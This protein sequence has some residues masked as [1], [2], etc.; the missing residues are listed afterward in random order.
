M[1]TIQAAY[2][3][4]FILRLAFSGD[5]LNL[6]TSV[7]ATLVWSMLF[8]FVFEMKKVDNKLSSNSLAESITRERRLRCKKLLLYSVFIAGA[9]LPVW[10]Y[11]VTVMA[12][13]D[14]PLPVEVVRAFDIAFVVRGLAA[15]ATHG[16]MHVQFGLTLRSFVKRK[17]RV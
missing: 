8:F 1:Y 16:Y 4:S 7:A 10:A 11:Y 3:A 9:V 14:D 17:R 6:M 12:H 13:H 15:V 2:L 5:S